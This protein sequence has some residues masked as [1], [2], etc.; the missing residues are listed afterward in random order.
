MRVHI[1]IFIRRCDL[2]FT[3]LLHSFRQVKA[4]ELLMNK[5]VKYSPPAQLPIQMLLMSPAFCA[6]FSYGVPVLGFQA[7][8]I[9]REKH[10]EPGEPQEEGKTRG[11]EDTGFSGLELGD[12][13]HLRQPDS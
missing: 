9:H 6:A 1:F 11:S 12:V 10:P 2:Y 8:S 7:R 13:F 5:S 4:N 3:L